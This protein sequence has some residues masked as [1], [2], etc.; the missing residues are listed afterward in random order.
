VED[1]SEDIDGEYEEPA[2]N[3][4]EVEEPSCYCKHG[5]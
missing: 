5:E 1:E 2:A 4:V 3:E